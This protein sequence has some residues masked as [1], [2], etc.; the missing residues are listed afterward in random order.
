MAVFSS[1]LIVPTMPD[2]VT[3][4]AMDDGVLSSPETPL[5][6]GRCAMRYNPKSDL[7]DIV[8]ENNGIAHASPSTPISNSEAN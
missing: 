8:D 7:F 4:M 6:N 1:Y 2:N 3:Q 5:T